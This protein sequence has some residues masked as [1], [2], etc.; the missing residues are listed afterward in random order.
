MK[1]HFEYFGHRFVLGV[2]FLQGD[3][4]AVIVIRCEDC[5]EEIKLP[6]KIDVLADKVRSFV[7]GDHEEDPSLN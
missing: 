1:K 6:F 2:P 5:G 3:E 4:A 7:G